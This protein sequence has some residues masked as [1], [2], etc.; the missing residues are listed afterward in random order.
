MNALEQL[1]AARQNWIENVRDAYVQCRNVD[2][3][4]MVEMPITDWE[5]LEKAIQ[6]TIWKAPGPISPARGKEKGR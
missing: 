5:L 4:D 2:M 1:A 3:G 6:A